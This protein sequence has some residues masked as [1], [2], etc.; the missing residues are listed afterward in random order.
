MKAETPTVSCA[1]QTIY[2]NRSSRPEID[3][4]VHRATHISDCERFG[5]PLFWCADYDQK[6]R[7]LK[8]CV[9]KERSARY[10]VVVV[11][12]YIRWRSNRTYG[13]KMEGITAR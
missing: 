8:S 10:E 12:E 5:I 11:R 7:P 13:T 2:F 4:R 9:S 3:R 1:E 6:I